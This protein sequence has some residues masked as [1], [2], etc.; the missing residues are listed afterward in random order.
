MVTF[1]VLSGKVPITHYRDIV[2]IQKVTDGV[3][4]ERPKGMEAWFTDDLWGMLELCQAAQPKSWPSIKALFE[5]FVR[6][7]KTWKPFSQ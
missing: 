5:Y 7:L 6:D 4:L 3:H 1:E 2:V